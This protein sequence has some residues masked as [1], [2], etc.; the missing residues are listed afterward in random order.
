M[1]REPKALADILAEVDALRGFGK[2][3]ARQRL[4]DAW[5]DVAGEAASASHPM[6]IRAGVLHVSV[7]SAGLLDELNNFRKAELLDA[8][9][10]RHAGLKLRGLRF[11]LA[12]FEAKASDEDLGF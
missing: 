1:R 12:R 6:H 4:V 5:A 7:R 10:E 3:N 9:R 11:R 2:T 8:L